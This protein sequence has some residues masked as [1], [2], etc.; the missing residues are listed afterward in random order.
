[1]PQGDE[2][3]ELLVDLDAVFG[4]A[5]GRRGAPLVIE[6]VRGLT[7][8]DVPAVL[9][10]QARASGQSLVRVTTAH[11]RLAQLIAQG[12]DNTEV[13]MM[14]G[15][16]PAYLSRLRSDPSFAELVS[17]Y[18]AERQL[19]FADVLLRMKDLGLSSLDELQARLADEPEKWTKREL[20]DL[21][22]LC[23]QPTTATAMA[24]GGQPQQG[25]VNINV[26]FVEAPPLRGGLVVEGEV[27][28]G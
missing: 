8:E 25:G 23:L 18:A 16:N 5:Q 26:N 22:E 9:A 13:S 4:S 1:M 27:L 6:V 28:S 21:A 11:H 2:P 20:M 12:K 14:T 7:V 24:K 17:T 3:Q 19:V 10:S 15:Y